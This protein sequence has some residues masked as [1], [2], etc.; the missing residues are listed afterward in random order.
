MFR[1]LREFYNTF[2]QTLE[3]GRYGKDGSVFS[4][5]WGQ[6]KGKIPATPKLDVAG[7]LPLL[8]LLAKSR[9]VWTA[10]VAAISLQSVIGG[11]AAV[12]G[13]GASFLALEY[14]RCRKAREQVI[15]ETNFAGQTV[16]GKRK[17][18]N[19]LHKAQEKIIE[20]SGVFNGEAAPPA[21]AELDAVIN[22]V[23]DHQNRVLVLQAGGF[24]AGAHHYEF[25]VPQIKKA[26]PPP[27][28]GLKDAW[29][30]KRDADP[31]GS[32]VDLEHAL[33]EGTVGNRRKRKPEAAPAPAAPSPRM[34][35]SFLG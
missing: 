28:A 23:R 2:S 30:N 29:D 14:H 34:E 17:D 19:R 33:R 32:L 1:K 31:L 20:L 35:M 12:A 6:V 26:A 4:D 13:A 16:R 25:S 8:G 5:L 3:D 15:T 10:L 11:L 21:Q 9:L 27:E 7:K 18:L 24:G 22:G